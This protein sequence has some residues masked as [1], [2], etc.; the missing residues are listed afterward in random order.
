MGG[1]AGC[2]LRAT[3]SA[4]YLRLYGYIYLH[5][6]PSRSDHE[7]RLYGRRDQDETAVSTEIEATAREIGVCFCGEEAGRWG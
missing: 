3:G 5:V 6:Q 7:R 2:G 1:G 4:F